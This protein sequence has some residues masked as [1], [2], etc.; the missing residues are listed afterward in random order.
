MS[1]KFLKLVLILFLVNS[2][3]GEDLFLPLPQNIKHNTKKAKLGKK[4]FLDVRLSGDETI[5]CATCHSL[6]NYGVDGL[7]TSFG[8]RGQKGSI[9]AP[10]VY[11]SEYNFVQFWDGR[12]KNLHE[13]A[14]GPIVNPIEMDSSFEKVV[15]KLSKDNSYKKEFNEIYSDGI[16]IENIVNAIAEF[17][18]T[19]ITP[20]SK[21]DKFLRKEITL[22]KEEAEGFKLF[23]SKGCIAC[24]NGINIGG[25]LFQKIGIFGKFKKDENVQTH[26]LGRF[27]VTKKEYDKFYF[28]V[29]SLR[30]IAKTAPY[31]HDGSIKT[32][33]EAVKKMAYHQLGR[34]LKKDEID[35]IV[36][37]LHTLTGE[38]NET[39]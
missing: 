39:E 34:F 38:I 14:K 25:N 29:P 8:I 35:K 26:D 6:Q 12:A 32:L 9:N 23:K 4:L 33:N 2:L 31:F 21:F 13:Q 10:T 27:N 19:L 5:S 1:S 17:E 11:N 28:K 36:K 16:T 7:K 15:L 18:K 3:S 30:N 20:N 22:S 37:F 24:H